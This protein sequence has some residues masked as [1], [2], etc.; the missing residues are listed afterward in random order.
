MS[1]PAI[2]RE[3]W[4]FEVKLVE[5]EDPEHWKDFDLEEWVAELLV[6]YYL[7]RKEDAG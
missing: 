6:D 7:R 5:A 2:K 3:D 1:E 4:K